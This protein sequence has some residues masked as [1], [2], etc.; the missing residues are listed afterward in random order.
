[1]TTIDGPF[2]ATSTAD[3]VHF[4][5][6]SS[7]AERVEVAIFDD[8]GAETRHPM[9]SQP[10]GVW[11]AF[12]EHAG[13]GTA[14]GYR[15]H[16][17]YDIARGLRCNPAKLLLDPYARAVSRQ[18]FW[19]QPMFAYPLGG[20]ETA[21][22]DTDSGPHA[23]RGFVV[24]DRFD[25]GDDRP[26]RHPPERVVIYELHVKGFT[27]QHPGVPKPLRGRYTGLAHPEAIAA[28]TRLGITAVELMPVQQFGHE[29]HLLEAGRRNYW[30]YHPYAYFAPHAEYASGDR[31]CQVAEFK[32]M[33]K[34]LHAA[35]LEVIIDVV[36]NHTAEGNH[37]GPTLNFKGLDN[38]AYYHLVDDDPRHYMDYTGTGNSLNLR[39]PNTLQLVMDSLRYWVNEMH[40]DGFRFDLA[41]TLARGPGTVD[42][43]AA[44]FATIHQDPSLQRVKLIAE[45]WDVGT[46][47]YQ[48]GNFPLHWSEWN[49][50][51]RET[52]RHCWSEG[53]GAG[54][55]A[56]RITGSPDLFQQTG[57]PP[58]A[59]INYVCSHDGLT[60]R[61][62]V[63]VQ[64]PDG[65]AAERG[66]RQRNLLAT[67][68]LSM[69]APMLAAGDE[70][71]RSQQGHDNPYDQDNEVSWLDWTSA[72]D[73]LVRFTADLIAARARLPW[74]QDDRW[75]S[76][77]CQLRWLRSD[78][79]EAQD[80]DWAESP[81]ALC[82]HATALSNEGVWLVNATNADLT[83]TLPAPASGRWQ[84]VVDTADDGASGVVANGPFTLGSHRIIVLLAWSG[85]GQD[86]HS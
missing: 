33:V 53:C 14:Y 63:A 8:A 28:L 86:A 10:G 83:Y 11:H 3:G 65:N 12:V 80:S 66:R 85:P 58:S 55:L 5:V 1:M 49:D 71:G 22:D 35:G 20:D 23:P 2:G 76:H 9:T 6:F 27:M 41:T 73:A 60:L 26:P 39:H 69:G 42:T 61:D 64:L 4:R 36:Y 34:A 51:F 32:A 24:D 44:F 56:R 15:A 78:G 31:G 29:P 57:R 17:P 81:A 84:L 7:V 50:R 74:L 19:Q 46:N 68:L 77:E 13:P 52:A 54:E 40:V 82:L 72:D 45:P 48:V 18:G 21:R 16:G 59:S 37:L 75:P 62:L 79:T 70:W 30:G 38:P 47:G 25:W 67:T 43:W